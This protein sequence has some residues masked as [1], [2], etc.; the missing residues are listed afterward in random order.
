MLVALSKKPHVYEGYRE[1]TVH[2]ARPPFLQ[3]GGTVGKLEGFSDPDPRM[4][5]V[6]RRRAANKVARRQRKVN[7]HA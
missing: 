5:R 2:L 7:A 3:P 6:D 1:D 4:A